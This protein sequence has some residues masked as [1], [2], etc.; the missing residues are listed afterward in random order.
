MSTYFANANTIERKWYVIDA[1]NN[2]RISSIV[3]CVFEVVVIATPSSVVFKASN[4][5]AYI[6]GAGNV[7]G[8]GNISNVVVAMAA[9]AT[10]NAAHVA[11]LR[12]INRCTV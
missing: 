10:G 9:K 4:H 5:P 12:G 7:S 1:A 6:I 3:N 2:A 11:C 8:V